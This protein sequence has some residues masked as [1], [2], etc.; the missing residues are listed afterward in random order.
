MEAWFFKL[1]PAI[2]IALGLPHL[3]KKCTKLNPPY[4]GFTTIDHGF[5]SLLGKFNLSNS[6]N[7]SKVTENP[8]KPLAT[9]D[10]E[11]AHETHYLVFP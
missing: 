6:H 1:I 3:H 9:E 10:A 2:N 5:P 8:Y 7:S 11:S 4:G